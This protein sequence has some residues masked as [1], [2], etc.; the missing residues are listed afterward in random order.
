MNILI[1]FLS[2]YKEKSNEYDYTYVEENVTYKGIQT[3]DAPVRCLMDRACKDK[4][5]I[6]KVLCIVSRKVYTETYV[7]NDNGETFTAYDRFVYDVLKAEVDVQPIYY[8]FD[9]DSGEII[10]QND[11]DEYIFKQMYNLLS[12]NIIDSNIY[13]DYTGGMRDINYLMTTITR[14]LEL[15]KAKCHEIVYSQFSDKR[16]Y[17][18]RDSYF[19]SVMENGIEEFLTTGRVSILDRAFKYPASMQNNQIKALLNELRNFSDSVTLCDINFMVDAV[20]NINKCMDRILKSENKDIGTEMFSVFIPDMKRDMYLDRMFDNNK[21]NP[22]WLIQWCVDNKLYQQALTLVESLMPEYLLNKLVWRVKKNEKAMRITDLESYES[23]KT[24]L[25]VEQVVNQAKNGWETFENYVFIRCI[26]Y[27]NPRRG[28]RALPGAV[29]KSMNEYGDELHWYGEGKKDATPTIY[30]SLI[31]C[32]GEKYDIG[33]ELLTKKEKDFNRMAM[34][35]IALKNQRNYSNHAKSSKEDSGEGIKQTLS[36][37]NKSFYLYLKLC[38]VI[39]E[40]E[41]YEEKK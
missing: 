22:I 21:F 3:N 35:H 36:D 19:I 24:K 17:S 29:L 25:T 27:T 13:I 7:N 34:L 8:D 4:N 30:H 1:L 9:V 41:M 15:K 31:A 40:E 37:L 2:D 33:L 28:A 38:K 20:G 11:V 39:T 18:L 23:E 32:N 10:N 14:L 26:M 12:D 5:P 16:I 6:D